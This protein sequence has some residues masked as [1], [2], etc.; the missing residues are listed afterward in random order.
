MSR[1]PLFSICIPTYNNSATLRETV[2]SVL[3]QNSSDFEIII[4]DDASTDGTPHIVQELDTH[5]GKIKA[6][7]NEENQ[8]LFHNHNCCLNYASGK[9]I[10][11]LHADD[12]LCEG[13]LLLWKDLLKD[14]PEIDGIIPVTGNRAPSN[15]N[16]AIQL[17]GIEDSPKILK[18]H[19]AMISGAIY[20]ELVFNKM[21]FRED[22]LS[23]DWEFP[24]RLLING[25]AILV[26]PE[27]V[28]QR[29]CGP[30]TTSSKVA[31][32]EGWLPH[33]ATALEPHLQN[34]SFRK[35]LL[36]DILN[37]DKSEVRNLLQ[38]TSFLGNQNFLKNTQRRLRQDIGDLRGASKYALA[39]S[40]RLFG[41][42]ITTVF[43]RL[44]HYLSH[45]KEL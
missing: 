35:A 24:L 27:K 37:W 19:G 9:W 39:T 32:R 13:T 34:P 44:Y 33:Q 16:K 20:K 42:K 29:Y 1:P 14:Y 45:L 43:V 5:S 17:S 11:F 4:V 10:A 26:S 36:E 6:Y 12:R 21:K 15:R 2:E 40:I 31:K 28:M 41:G 22:T 8:G 25:G 7:M 3:S 23:G 38:I 30:D 18:W